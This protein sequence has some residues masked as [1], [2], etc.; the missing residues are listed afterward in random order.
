MT[1]T[2]VLIDVEGLTPASPE[3]VR[4]ALTRMLSIGEEGLAYHGYELP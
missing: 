3:F 2:E 4:V 1:T